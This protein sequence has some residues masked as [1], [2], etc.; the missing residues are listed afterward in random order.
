MAI[1]QITD[2][3]THCF[4]GPQISGKPTYSSFFLEKSLIESSDKPNSAI[5][6]LTQI[7][8]YVLY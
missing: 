8:A 1:I 5:V 3:Q 4:P 7:E 2:C 6:V